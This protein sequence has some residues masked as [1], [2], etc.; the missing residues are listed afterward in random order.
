MRLLI[1]DDKA[2]LCENLR[3]L[4]KQNSCALDIALN[5]DAG[6]EM[7]Q[8]GDYSVILLDIMMPDISGYK[9]LSI[10]R[11][12]G[13]TTPVLMLTA[14]DTL[15]DKVGAF[16]LGSDDYLTKPFEF[17]ELLARVNALAR[18]SV[19]FVDS[20][21]SAGA[22]GIN[23]RTYEAT[24]NGKL[25]KTTFNESKVLEILFMNKGKYVSKE[26]ILNILCG[27]YKN[28]E[29]NNVEVYVHYLRRKFPCDLSGFTIETKRDVGYR[30]ME[31]NHA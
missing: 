8:R 31:I 12:R 13:I 4:F 29:S 1:I 28:I 30:L 15:E 10:L 17:Q 2:E 7:A 5:G 14:K 27:N 22:V 3:R 9:V 24:L 26:N 6:V 21:I 18:R 19:T 23:R 11:N 16:K 25:V 20:I